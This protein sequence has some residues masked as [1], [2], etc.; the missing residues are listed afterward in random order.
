MWT[1]FVFVRY[2]FLSVAT[3]MNIVPKDVMPHSQVEIE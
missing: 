3:M 1:L 2:E